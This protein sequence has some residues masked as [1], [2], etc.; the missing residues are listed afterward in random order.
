VDKLKI[1]MKAFV[2]SETQKDRTFE[3]EVVKIDQVANAGQGWWGGDD[4]KRFK[5]EVALK[6]TQLNL[7]TGTSARAEVQVDEID[8]VLTVPLQAV[9]DKE[10]KRFCFRRVKGIAERVEVTLGT[11]NDTM[12]EVKSG[13]SED[14]VVLLS[15]PE[16]KE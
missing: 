2:T 5:V 13:L 14:D 16:S 10:G 11:S 12:V 3:G 1:G 4:V 8:G 15:D 9:H 7:K 6:G